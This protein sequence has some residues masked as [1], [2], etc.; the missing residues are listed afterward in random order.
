MEQ[1]GGGVEGML[2]VRAMGDDSIVVV[3][4][5]DGGANSAWPP[6]KHLLEASL[7]PSCLYLPRQSGKT[8]DFPPHLTSPPRSAPSPSP[9][10]F[11]PS[12]PP[13]I[14]APR[15]SP[16]HSTPHLILPPQSRPT[17]WSLSP[18]S[19]L[20]C[21]SMKVLPDDDD[22]QHILSR[23]FPPRIP[24]ISLLPSVQDIAATRPTPTNLKLGYKNLGDAGAFR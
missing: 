3:D 5:E 13:G 14:D 23:T 6:W 24:D 19:T 2:D 22:P 4:K 21:L 18:E 11:N 17:P 12:F 7:P 20:G 10:Q 15:N 16:P 1:A 8:I 9:S